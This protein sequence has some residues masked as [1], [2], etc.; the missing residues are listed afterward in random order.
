MRAGRSNEATLGAALRL[1]VELWLAIVFMAVSFA[2]GTSY[3]REYDGHALGD[4]WAW[5]KDQ[6]SYRLSELAAYVEE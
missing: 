5:L 6:K 1:R 3:Y 4:E 2:A